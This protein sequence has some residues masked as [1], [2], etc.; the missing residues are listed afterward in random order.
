MKSVF[1]TIGVIVVSFL[2]QAQEKFSFAFFTDLHL[3]TSEETKSFDALGKALEHAKSKKVDFVLSG[4]DNVDVDAYKADQLPKA[5]SMFQKYK[6]QIDASKMKYYYAIGNH[7]RYWHYDGKDG[8]GLFESVFGKSYY[9]FEHKGWRFIVLNS[10]QIC[11]GKYCVDDEQKAWLEGVLASTPKNQPIVLVAHVPF[12]SLYYPVLEGKYTDADTF[13][14][15]KAV[16]DLFGQHNLKLVLQGHQHLYEEIK[17][18]GVQFITAGAIC[19]SWWG[20][21]FHGTQ[22]GYLK[23]DVNGDKF[24]W[25]Y[26]D[27][28]W[29][30][31]GK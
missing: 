16:F 25:D 13:S 7:D 22:E 2:A 24:K 29:T 1:L 12:L 5:K 9:S 17:V 31:N 18:K 15:Q 27:Y 30:V 3:N 14:N 26:I 4:G 21:P 11:N 6:D 20:G 10:A 28:G 23:V 19:A 8:A